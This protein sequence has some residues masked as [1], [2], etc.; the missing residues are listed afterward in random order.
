MNAWMGIIAAGVMAAGGAVAQ[1]AGPAD[2]VELALRAEDYAR[3]DTLTRQRIA[4]SER[5]HGPESAPTLQAI[6]Q[7]VELL[8]EGELYD[9]PE[10][11]A[12]IEREL[13]LARRLNN[14]PSRE[15]ARA[16]LHL[17]RRG[18][19]RADYAA[20][21]TSIAAAV[22][23]ARALPADDADRAEID[24]LVGQGDY[25][26]LD[27]QREGMQRAA[28]ALDVLR[29]AE[30]TH[31][32][33]L[34]RALC[35][36]G[37]M[38]RD[39]QDTTEAVR[40]L[41]ECEQRAGALAGR[42]SAARGRALSLLGYAL[43]EAGEFAAGI[44]ALTE[45][46]DLAA[47]ATPY[48]QSQ[49]VRALMV[50]G[51]NLEILGDLSRA[52][53]ALEAAHSLQEKKPTLN[54]FEEATLLSNLA[55]HYYYS[56]DLP[57]AL[58][59]D[60]RA[61]PLFERVLGPNASTVRM[62]RVNHAALLQENGR[63]D[64]A[65]DIYAREIV[66]YEAAPTPGDGLLLSYANLAEVRLRQGRFVDSE[67][68]YE[69]FL[70]RLGA[71]RDLTE[72]TPAGA[73]AGVAA[74]RWGQKRYAAAFA[75]VR[76]AQASSMRARQAALDELSERQMLSLASMNRDF[77]ALALAIAADSGDAAL[78]EQAWQW[79]VEA[80]GAVTHRA[81]LR[82]ADANSRR[83]GADDD[84]WREWRAAS[85]ALS[86]AR[87]VAAKR[88]SA[89]AISALDRAQNRVERSERRIAALDTQG[90]RALSAELGSLGRV[91]AELAPDTA[92]VRYVE[93]DVAGPRSYRNDR[94]GDDG[95][96]LALVGEPGEPVRAV[97]L[98]P[99]SEIVRRVQRWYALASLRDADAASTLAAGKALYAG[100]IA[101]L[102][103]AARTGR[104]HVIPSAA[105]HRLN[106]AALVAEDDR[107]LAETGPIFHLLNHER[108]FL[109]PR[110]DVRTS[111][112]LLAGAAASDD[113]L[114]SA[115]GLAPA[116]R[117]ACPGIGPDQ[118][119]P[120]PGAASEI[121]ALRELAQG[122]AGAIDVLSGAAATEA[123]V[124]TAMPGRSMIHLA[125]HAFAF[126]DRC[127]DG[128]ARRSITLDAA[129]FG[130][131]PA[132]LTDL[133]AL[134]FL[135]R[136]TSEAGDD[137]LLTSEEVATLNLSSAD[138]VVLSACETALGKTQA[139]EGVF[140]L[141]RAFRLAGA[142][143]VVMS[144]WKVEDEAT[145]EFMRALYAARLIEGRDTPGAMQAAMRATLDARRRRGQS[146]H[147]LY[148]AGFV[149]AGAWR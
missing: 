104:V 128:D 47:R 56:G 94:R 32:R 118:L 43:R 49:H 52:R 103:L 130:G 141:R 135:P 111:G 80:D 65:A 50:L 3:A 107:Y 100:L 66:A 131:E 142:R 138:W 63:L 68:L 2:P 126:G 5:E 19:A 29:A 120:L 58:A 70:R 9:L 82:L 4:D 38:K 21:R 129:P 54:P 87:V 67:G 11:S 91:H 60:E 77:G 8:L 149:A 14:E 139:G 125:T 86:A 20:F 88:P 39:V 74:A 57:R 113:A 69:R 132:G 122:R 42:D 26:V 22:A 112:L 10:T 110:A 71:G 144:L 114:A 95:E 27:R 40:L 13:A 44:D 147:P 85:E 143:T 146:A 133:S 37:R 1:S 124:R 134:A 28:R 6:D 116:M 84:A 31:A 123:A 75:A 98:G 30:S 137:G 145:A 93:L 73:L 101:P 96:L 53:T 102:Q 34:L 46:A 51:A 16:R 121:A 59:F 17:A 15:A 90:A 127:T 61:L 109:L 33:A 36:Y 25:Q 23:A 41:R 97:A 76:R 48:N 35:G 78:I 45:G 148:W 24:S 105:L 99:S 117:K 106:F 55:T 81:T 140:G 12:L 18:Y 62:A 108:E 64:A 92:L 119:G 83:N 72:T 115:D 136:P 79:I 7:R 89:G